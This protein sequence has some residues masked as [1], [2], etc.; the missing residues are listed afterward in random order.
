MHYIEV[1]F[2][3]GF[4]GDSR[5]DKPKPKVVAEV[6]HLGK[7]GEESLGGTLATL[8]GAPKHHLFQVKGA[9]RGIA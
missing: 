2:Q 7:G 5:V 9:Y 3:W 4:K 1:I 6:E 8:L